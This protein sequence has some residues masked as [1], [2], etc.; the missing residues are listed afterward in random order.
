[1]IKFIGSFENFDEKNLKNKFFRFTTTSLPSISYAF[2]PTIYERDVNNNGKRTSE[3]HHDQRFE[4][5]ENK[6]GSKE[7][8][9]E[10]CK[11][12][13]PDPQSF[14]P[15]RKFFCPDGPRTPPEQPQNEFEVY[16]RRRL[17]RIRSFDDVNSIDKSASASENDVVM[18]PS[19]AK[20]LRKL[21][22]EHQI[23]FDNAFRLISCKFL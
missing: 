9:N 21:R 14:S 18:S 16:E 19:K 13:Q 22:V 5:S 23:L 7:E 15:P 11:F 8:M 2:S 4:V 3:S 1:M 20:R 6:S 12:T 17:P 10:L